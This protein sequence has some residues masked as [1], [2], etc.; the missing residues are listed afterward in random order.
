MDYSD[1]TAN[2]DAADDLINQMDDA[3][4]ED[5][6]LDD[7]IPAPHTGPSWGWGGI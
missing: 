4:L 7:G 6:D 3:D 1:N 2:D 5:L